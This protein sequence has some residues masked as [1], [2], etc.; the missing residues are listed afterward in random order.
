MKNHHA[1]T[2]INENIGVLRLTIDKA[3]IPLE[4]K[5]K[6]TKVLLYF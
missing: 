6:I 5:S 2:E 1:Q 3:F 4:I